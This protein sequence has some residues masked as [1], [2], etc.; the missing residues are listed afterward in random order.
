MYVIIF[1]HIQ[2]YTCDGVHTYTCYIETHM[3]YFVART[4]RYNMHTCIYNYIP[5]YASY[6]E[7]CVYRM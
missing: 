2:T 7:V 1:L 4:T 6:I 5:I 3:F